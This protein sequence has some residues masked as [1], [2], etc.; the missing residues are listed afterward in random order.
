M[1][2][3]I[4]S[5]AGVGDNVVDCNYT[6]KVMYPGGNCV[7]FA[8][9]GRQIGCRSA[10]IGVVGK[11]EE[12]TLI[13]DALVK[14]GVDVSRC[15]RVE[16]ETGRCG[17]HLT[18]GDRTIVEENDK[19]VVKSQPLLITEELLKHL[20]T[21]DI[22]HSSCYSCLE[23]QL[24]KIKAA[25]I[26]LLYDF[27][28]EWTE[29]KFAAICPNL[30]FAFFSGKDLAV[31]ELSDYLRKIVDEYGCE[32]AITTIGERGALVY[33]GKQVY[34][35]LP[36]NFEGGVID[37]TGAGDSWITGFITTYISLKNRLHSLTVNSPQNYL[38]ES[39]QDDFLGCVIET[40]MGAGNLLARRN[41]LVQGSFNEGVPLPLANKEE[42]G[43]EEGK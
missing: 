11:D 42:K 28:D 13:L 8:V 41:C 32:L 16:G 15:I 9:F 19:G 33:D 6:S 31:D 3:E 23:D 20:E 14:R 36:Y 35:K 22:V 40:A 29:E 43:K 30:R 26:S 38:Q 39:D 24:Y 17:I 34:R 37:T 4:L 27:S 5:I 1:K 2:N 7:N 21:Y 25:G 12:G 10:Y 18:N